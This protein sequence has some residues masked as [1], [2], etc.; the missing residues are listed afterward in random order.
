MVTRVTGEVKTLTGGQQTPYNSISLSDDFYMVPASMRTTIENQPIVI[1][2]AAVMIPFVIADVPDGLQV[3]INGKEV[4]T[5][6]YSTTIDSRIPFGV[7]LRGADYDTH[8]ETVDP[9]GQE[10]VYLTPYLNFSVAYTVRNLTSSRTELANQVKK[11]KGDSWGTAL[12]ANLGLVTALAGGG[13]AGYS[14]YLAEQSLSA[15]QGATTQSALTSARTSMTA[16][17][18]LFKIGLGVLG[19][20]LGSWFLG[21]ALTPNT[22]KVE[23]QIRIIDNQIESW[24]RS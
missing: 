11:I 10:R 23:S 5:T 15:Y 18:Q 19:G 13:V 7:E 20:G 9:V 22:T 4:G 6:P 2:A 17:N 1:T 14:W 21:W 12:I 3:L 8:K 16:A 24:K